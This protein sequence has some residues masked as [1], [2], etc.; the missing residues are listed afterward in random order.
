MRGCPAAGID[1]PPRNAHEALMSR[2]TSTRSGQL[3]IGC[4]LFLD[5]T[6]YRVPEN[7]LERLQATFPGVRIVLGMSLKLIA[8]MV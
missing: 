8:A 2:D 1:W 5:L 6:L 4:D 3:T 7:I